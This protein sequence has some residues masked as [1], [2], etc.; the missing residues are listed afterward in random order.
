MN[1]PSAGFSHFYPEVGQYDSPGVYYPPPI[2]SMMPPVTVPPQDQ[3]F[4]LNLPCNTYPQWDYTNDCFSFYK[5]GCYNECR[6][7]NVCDIEDFM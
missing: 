7:V 6:F 5:D 4:G 2:P 3:Q 1:Y